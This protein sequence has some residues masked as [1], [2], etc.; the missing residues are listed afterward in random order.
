MKLSA[1]LAELRR[2]NVLRAGALYVAIAWAL[3]QGVAQLLPVF[4]A[5]D[6]LTRWIVL[7]AAIGFPFWLAFAWY[8]ELTPSGLKRES[9]IDAADSITLQTGRKLD[10]LIIGILGV[11]VIL[12][13][14]DRL[15]AHNNANA[16]PENSIAVLPLANDGGNHGQ[17]YFSDGLSEDFIDALSHFPGLRVIGRN[18]AFQFRNSQDDAKTIGVKL[19]VAYLLEGSVRHEAD[20]VRISAELVDTADASTRW[21]QHYDRPYKDLFAL[22]DEVTQAVANALHARLLDKADI[23]IQSD[24]PPGGELDAYTNYLQG[25]FLERHNTGHDQRAAIEKYA[26]A[27]RIDPGYAFADARLSNAWTVLGVQFLA[28]AQAQQAFSSAR[29]AATAALALEP[30]LAAAHVARGYLLLTADQDWTG[31]AA[32]YGHAIQLAPHDASAL[33]QLGNLLAAL[34]HPQRA[35]ELTRRALPSDPLHASWYLWLATYLTSLDRLDEAETAIHQAIAQEPAAVS[36]R[37]Q[38]A[39][40]E[41]Q[42]GDAA[43]ALAAAQQEPPGVWKDVALALTQQV[44]AD[45]PAADAA[46]KALIDKWADDA[47]YQI[48]QVYALRGDPVN[49]FKWLDRASAVRDPGIGYL[50]YDPFILRYRHDPRFLAFCRK[51]GLP[52]VTHALR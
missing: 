37:E 25:K 14:T 45:H 42:R 50:L 12:L 31:A 5:P 43:A 3:A 15:V 22:Q 26:D 6:W 1:W 17:Q 46:L 10:F 52:T 51:V 38:L 29:A 16:A 21:S 13:L 36:Y 27:V 28:G 2:R 33:F 4:G 9:E 18:S 41:I 23:V 49:T 35:V 19:G 32:E 48:A 39:I 7:A 44:S 40:I 11:V 8:Y 34:G 24:R 30:G 47:P 20:T